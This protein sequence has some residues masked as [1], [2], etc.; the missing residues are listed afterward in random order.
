MSKD[1]RSWPGKKE[2]HT[3]QLR[4]RLSQGRAEAPR[5]PHA[6]DRNAIVE[7]GVRIAQE[8]ST[9]EPI[10]QEIA[11][12]VGD[13]VVC[14]YA[15]SMHSPPSGTGPALTEPA[16]TGPVSLTSRTTTVSSG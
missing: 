13:N 3:E 15:L 2:T 6:R 12:S 11:G 10:C 9:E 7:Y 1:S 16:Q 4:H 14:L 8:R 5:E